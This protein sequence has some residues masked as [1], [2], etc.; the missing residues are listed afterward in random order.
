MSLRDKLR[1]ISW[2]WREGRYFDFWSISHFFSGVLL[3]LIGYLSPLSFSDVFLFMLVFLIVYE[4]WE[5]MVRIG[6]A[7]ENRV[8][9]VVLGALGFVGAYRLSE[10]YLARTEVFISAAFVAVA[11]VLLVV[12]GW[13]SYVRHRGKVKQS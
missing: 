6:E 10:M 11:L 8:T 13:R 12:V 7:I 5:G 3:G 2:S 4:M 9:D 1:P